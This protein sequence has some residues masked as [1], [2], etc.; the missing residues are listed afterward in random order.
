MSPHYLETSQELLWL[1]HVAFIP[2]QP[3]HMVLLHVHPP[4]LA[5]QRAALK[6]CDSFNLGWAN[7]L[8]YN[9]QLQRL[10]EGI[11]IQHR[12][13]LSFKRREI[14]LSMCVNIQ[15]VPESFGK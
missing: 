12:H 6:S 11:R 14:K 10:K 8:A 5:F 9:R 15:K 7:C 3:L 1:D 2:T 4:S 13:C